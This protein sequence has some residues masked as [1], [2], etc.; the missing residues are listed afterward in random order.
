MKKLFFLLIFFATAFAF[1]Q[2]WDPTVKSSVGKKS[3]AESKIVFLGADSAEVHAIFVFDVASDS[4][5]AALNSILSAINQI[6]NRDATP[7]TKSWSSNSTSTTAWDTLTFLHYTD[8]DT[9]A[10]NSQK[11]FVLIDGVSTDSVWIHK[12]DDTP[13]KTSPNTIILTGGEGYTFY[14]SRA[15]IHTIANGTVKRRIYAEGR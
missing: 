8:T 2:D 9:T 15:T 13:S 7:F 10:F 3:K 5:N 14:K 1:A 12:G 11:T 4:G 6:N